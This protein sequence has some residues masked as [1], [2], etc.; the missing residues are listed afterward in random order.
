MML[1]QELINRGFVEVEDNDD[2][3]I[4]KC[5]IIKK[6]HL[7]LAKPYDEWCM[8]DSILLYEGAEYPTVL[9]AG[10]E[11]EVDV[12]TSKFPFKVCYEIK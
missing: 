4:E 12:D 1:L 2:E 8:V 7:V 6:G 10:G 5:W 9:F 11:D 3:E